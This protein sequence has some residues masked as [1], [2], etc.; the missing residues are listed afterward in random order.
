[1]LPAPKLDLFAGIPVTSYAEAQ[2]WYERLLGSPQAFFPNDTEAVWELAEHRYVYIVEQR[3]HAGH[4]RLTVYVENLDSLVAG[5]AERGLES[6]MRESYPNGVR[7]ITCR[8]I[9]GNE[10]SFGGAPKRGTHRSPRSGRKTRASTRLPTVS[11]ER[12]TSQ[13]TSTAIAAAKR[14]HREESSP[15]SSRARRFSE[16][17]VGGRATCSTCDP[18]KCSVQ[19][20]APRGLNS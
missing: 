11:R 3:E 17:G 1:M 16:E 7:K 2:K 5:I 9:D 10:I 12:A 20:A 4:A 18:V 14:S 19:A 13:A 6:A 15:L 8:D